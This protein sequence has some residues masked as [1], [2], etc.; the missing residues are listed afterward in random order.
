MWLHFNPAN[1]AL[2]LDID[3]TLLDIAKTPKDVVVSPELIQDLSL[4]NNKLKGALALV[5]GRV[6]EEVDDLF[7]PLRLRCAGAHGAQ[8]RLTPTGSIETENPLPDRL[9]DDIA[10]AFEGIEGVFVEDKIYNIAVH[11]RQAT[12]QAA[13]IGKNLSNI[14]QDYGNDVKI[15][16]GRKVFE[17]T[18]SSYNKGLAIEKL[19]AVSPF[20]NRRPVFLGDDTTDLPAIGMCLKKGGIA[21][22]VGKG[23]SRNHAFSS[24]KDVR[25]WINKIVTESN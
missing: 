23:K 3:G 21:A 8:W 18:L 16:S 4:L 12:K 15:I 20:K 25:A 6:I 14:V 9:R 7:K 19:L 2:F 5:S 1:D 24:P 13:T 22:R 10:T 11:Y 17:V